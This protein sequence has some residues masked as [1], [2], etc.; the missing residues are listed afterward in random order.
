MLTDGSGTASVCELAVAIA[1]FP[2]PRIV[3]EYRDWPAAVVPAEVTAAI[4][5]GP[6][7]SLVVEVPDGCSG[8]QHVNVTAYPEH[9]ADPTVAT[10][11]PAGAHSQR[12]QLAGLGPWR[13]WVRSRDDR[14]GNSAL[15]A[16]ACPSFVR[17][18]DSRQL[19]DVVVLDRSD[20]LLEVPS[21]AGARVTV[22][23]FDRPDD[24]MA[25]TT[26]DDAGRATLSL[27]ATTGTSFCVRLDKDD[28]CWIT[29]AHVG[30]VARP[31]HYVN[32]DYDPA[33]PCGQCPA[34]VTTEPR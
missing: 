12:F 4:T 34:A 30:G 1:R 31:E 21:F 25:T 6:G 19:P 2:Q 15:E 16:Y 7:R 24:V 3:V 20:M 14:A 32:R 17:V 5:I 33:I 28:R 13:Y 22:R 23:P 11:L 9:G 29:Y 8:M 18:V 26:L 10:R 27:A